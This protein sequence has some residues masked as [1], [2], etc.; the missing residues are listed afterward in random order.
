MAV[1]T[2]N[3]YSHVIGMSMEMVVTLPE[4]VVHRKDRDARFPVLYLLHGFSDNHTAWT[5]HTN[6]ERYA[7]KAGIIVVMPNAHQS[8]YADMAHGQKYYTFISQELPILIRTMFP[9]SQKREDTYIAGLSMG[10][11][12]AFKI[13]LANP[14][15]YSVIGG[16]SAGAENIYAL[17]EVRREKGAL[18]NLLYDGAPPA[19]TVEDPYWSAQKILKE[20]LPCPRIW[21]ACGK[22]DPMIE[23]VYRT[24]DYFS[25]LEGNPF[26][27]SYEEGPGAHEWDFWDGCVRRFLD[28]IAE[29]R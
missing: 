11:F 9:I 14:H 18:S 22:D 13:G 17:E 28:S 5:R 3:V 7:D 1:M 20:G 25:S 16:F 15:K 23:R 2:V 26:R 27:Y 4:A 10:G 24:R 21:H 6:I 19:E 12:G 8:N 29:E